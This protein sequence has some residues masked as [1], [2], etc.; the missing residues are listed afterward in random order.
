M[1]LE[2]FS[3]LDPGPYHTAGQEE[4]PGTLLCHSKKRLETRSG[5]K[6]T[7]QFPHHTVSH[8]DFVTSPSL[9]LQGIFSILGGFWRTK[10]CPRVVSKAKA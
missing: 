8:E 6:R 4:G 5:W 7:V 9:G 1:V 3:T 10:Q 2:E